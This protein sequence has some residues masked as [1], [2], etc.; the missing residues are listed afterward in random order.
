M[1]SGLELHAGLW[2]A[3]V[4]FIVLGELL[5]ALDSNFFLQLLSCPR[6][7]VGFWVD[8]VNQKSSAPRCALLPRR[9]SPWQYT[10][11]LTQ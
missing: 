2:L 4:S 6:N 1:A 8:A 5:P 7:A 10:T 3:I 9:L 11:L